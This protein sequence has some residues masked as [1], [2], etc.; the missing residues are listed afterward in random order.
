MLQMLNLDVKKSNDG[1]NPT[2][3]YAENVN[4]GEGSDD[5][6]GRSHSIYAKKE[7]VLPN[8][9]N[10]HIMNKDG[11]NM[12]ADNIKEEDGID[13]TYKPKVYFF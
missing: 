12:S 1:H 9:I 11:I 3:Q 10:A 4:N 6:F 5:D 2:N 8:V 13:T 7:L